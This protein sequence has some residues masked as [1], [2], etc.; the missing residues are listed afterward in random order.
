M[1]LR[2]SENSFKIGHT[3]PITPTTLPIG[4]QAH[5]KKTLRYRKPQVPFSFSPARETVAMQ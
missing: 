1:Q 3:C 4:S 5:R 2:L